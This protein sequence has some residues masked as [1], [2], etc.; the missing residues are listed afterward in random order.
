MSANEAPPNPDTYLY[1][2]STEPGRLDK[3]QADHGTNRGHMQHNGI[4]CLRARDISDI[5]GEMQYSSSVA[6]RRLERVLSIWIISG[7]A[8]DTTTSHPEHR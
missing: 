1:N 6:V 4:S 7:N 8:S 5:S 3:R 2:Q